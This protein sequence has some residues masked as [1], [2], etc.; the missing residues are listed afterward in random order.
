MKRLLNSLAIA[1]LMAFA[2]TAWAQEHGHEGDLLLG[3]IG[4][5]LV[6]LGP[7][8]I[9]HPPFWLT[10]SMEPTGLGFYVVDVGLDFALKHH[11]GE[12]DHE[13]EPLLRQVTIKQWYITPGLFGVVEGE[14]DPVFG[15]GTPG[16]LTL[17]FDPDNPEAVHRHIIFATERFRPPSLFQFQ[18][19]NGI[20]YG[21]TPLQD[22]VVYTLQ[23]TPVPEPATLTAL[24]A[25]VGLLGLARRRRSR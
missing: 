16:E 7:E 4:D 18:L 19:V 11:E 23:L 20:A 5:E 17:V 8:E 9:T 3:Y 13:H 10:V 6:L 12:P 24:A 1:L 15:R 14:V 21:G 22:S 25:G 2:I